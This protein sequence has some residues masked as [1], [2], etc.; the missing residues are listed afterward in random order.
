MHMGAFYLVGVNWHHFFLICKPNG[1]LHI[2]GDY[3]VT[4]IIKISGSYPASNIKSSLQALL[5]ILISLC[6]FIPSDKI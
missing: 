1:A 6:K 3:K 2:C 5:Y 4:L